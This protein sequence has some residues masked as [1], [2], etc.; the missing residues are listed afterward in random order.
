VLLEMPLA[1]AALRTLQ[2]VAWGGRLCSTLRSESVG[3]FVFE[4][5]N[6]AR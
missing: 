2:W 4:P 6:D 5:Y 1:C 3:N